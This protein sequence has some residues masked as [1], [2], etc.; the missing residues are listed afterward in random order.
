MFTSI[1][2]SVVAHVC[3]PS[4][5][6]TALR[7]RSA[8]AT[9]EDAVSKKN[10]VARFTFK[11]LLVSLGDWEGHRGPRGLSILGCFSATCGLGKSYNLVLSHGGLPLIG[12]S[13]P[14]RWSGLHLP[15]PRP[16][17]PLD[18][19][20]SLAFQWP[21]GQQRDQKVQFLPIINR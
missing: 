16:P 10:K 3:N 4:T 19:L 2:P 11:F 15:T 20:H 5:R 17:G 12:P 9:W 6:E 8:W 7:S 14:F 18:R 21:W 13:S 1:E